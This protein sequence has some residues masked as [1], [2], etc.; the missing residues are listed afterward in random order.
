MSAEGS[1]PS[2]NSPNLRRRVST[3]ASSVDPGQTSSSQVGCASTYSLHQCREVAEDFLEQYLA[4]CTFLEDTTPVSPSRPVLNPQKV[5]CCPFSNLRATSLRLQS[6]EHTWDTLLL[7][8][9]RLEP[10]ELIN[11]LSRNHIIEVRVSKTINQEQDLATQARNSPGSK[12]RSAQIQSGTGSNP[13]VNRTNR[14]RY[15]GI[16][17]LD[18]INPPAQPSPPTTPTKVHPKGRYLELPLS[19]NFVD[20]LNQA[21][22]I[23]FW[24]NEHGLWYEVS[25]F[26]G[27]REG[28]WRDA[29]RTSPVL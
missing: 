16:H 4:Q 8:F 12:H 3:T 23:C 2:W 19:E 5:L 27:N 26:S 1:P 11:S 25:I 14:P 13:V 24:C 21:G 18:G 29:A 7:R 20:R 10:G 22:S 9:L 15:F 17:L 28:S 6:N